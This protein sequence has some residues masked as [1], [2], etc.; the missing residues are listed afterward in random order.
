MLK[1]KCYSVITTDTYKKRPIRKDIKYNIRHTLSISKIQYLTP[2]L[3][4]YK[5][6]KVI[7]TKNLYPN[8]GIVNGVHISEL[9]TYQNPIISQLIDI[10]Y[11]WP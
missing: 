8:I 2:F 4:I 1:Q 10:N 6:M 11:H 3:K 7:I 9:N 5:G